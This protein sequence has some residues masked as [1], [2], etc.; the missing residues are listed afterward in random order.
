MVTNTNREMNLVSS[1]RLMSNITCPGYERLQ[2]FKNSM[3]ETYDLNP[4]DRRH[5]IEREKQ[6]VKKIFYG[7]QD[8][9]YYF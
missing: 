7:Q 3:V 6:L 1:I 8:T 4:E 9:T 5:T 2:Q